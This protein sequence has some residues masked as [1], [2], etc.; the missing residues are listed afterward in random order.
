MSEL[1]WKCFV[2]APF[3]VKRDKEC[4]LWNSCIFNGFLRFKLLLLLSHVF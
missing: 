1:V 2:N 3:M 4:S